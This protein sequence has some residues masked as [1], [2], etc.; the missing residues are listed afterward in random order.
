M[1][2]PRECGWKGGDS[3]DNSAE[4]NETMP[5]KHEYPT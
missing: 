4:E 3:V 2:A 5:N 1:I